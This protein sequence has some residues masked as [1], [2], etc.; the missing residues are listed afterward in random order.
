LRRLR[1]LRSRLACTTTPLPLR[2]C[3]R[4]LEWM[5]DRCKG[6][7]AKMASIET[8]IG[9]VPDV[10]HGGLNIEGLGMDEKVM[11]ELLK[12]DPNAWAKEMKT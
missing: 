10:A 7:D 12:V 9:F 8:P 3:S 6:A 1:A 5:L 11:A 2:A 4:V